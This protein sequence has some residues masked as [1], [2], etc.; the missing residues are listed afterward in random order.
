MR[1]SNGWAAFWDLATA[2]RVIDKATGLT[3]RPIESGGEWKVPDKEAERMGAYV[4]VER[5]TADWII[6][7]DPALRRSVWLRRGGAMGGSRREVT[8]P[9]RLRWQES[10]EVDGVH[11]DVLEAPRG[12]ALSQLLRRDSGPHWGS[13]RYWLYDLVVEVAQAS[14]DGT[15]P[16]R[17]GLDQV[18]ITE[19]GRAILLD[20][21]IGAPTT[22]L[23]QFDASETRGR[24]GFLDAVASTVDFTTVPFHARALLDSLK[25]GTFEKLSFIAGNLRSL[26]RKPDRIDPANRAASIL[27]GPLFLVAYVLLVVLVTWPA[28]IRARTAALHAMYPDLPALNDVLRFRYSVPREDRRFIHIHLAGH[29]DHEQFTDYADWDRYRLLTDFEKNLLKEL[30]VPGPVFTPEELV[31]S[32]Q[33]LVELLPPFLEGGRLIDPRRSFEMGLRF[34]IRC[35]TVVAFVQVL[36]LLI[37]QTSIGQILFGIGIVDREGK[38]LG[39]GGLL[40]RCLIGWAFFG[41]S[42]LMILE[43]P[44]LALVLLFPWLIGIGAAIQRPTRGLHDHLCGTWLVAR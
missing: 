22:A 41:V 7:V 27:I 9:G 10:I 18:W 31:E 3:R 4:I 26:L 13:M 29:Y 40:F 16:E 5:V 1:R 33:R 11:W 24:V 12:I 20:E 30:T 25:A 17:L 44:P 37:F 32:D 36:S 39:R 15:L 42:A 34:F 19:S 2:T 38:P 35:M 21:S 28:S 23:P 43:F 6:G 14:H 8:R